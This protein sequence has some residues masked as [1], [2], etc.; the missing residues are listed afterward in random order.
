MTFPIERQRVLEFGFEAEIAG[1][2]EEILT[3]TKV[4]ESR[5][6]FVVSMLVLSDRLDRQ[7]VCNSILCQ[8][9]TG[10]DALETQDRSA[11]T[12]SCAREKLAPGWMEGG[13]GKIFPRR[14]GRDRGIV[15]KKTDCSGAFT[16]RVLA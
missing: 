4:C 5:P 6:I 10:L 2:P 12:E 1:R 7:S 15:P 3:F 13:R 8:E 11:G 9:A 14:D 16:F